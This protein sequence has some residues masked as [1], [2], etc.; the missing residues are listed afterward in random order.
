MARQA[1]ATQITLREFVAYIQGA[2]EESQKYDGEHGNVNTPIRYGELKNQLSTNLDFTLEE[3]GTAVDFMVREGTL[4]LTIPTDKAG[5]CL[6]FK[7]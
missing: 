3:L 1:A 5:F 6:R 4:E 2:I 7:N